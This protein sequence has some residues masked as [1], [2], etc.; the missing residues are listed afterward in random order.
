MFA[1]CV[2]MTELGAV[3]KM[4]REDRA[5]VD[6]WTERANMAMVTMK[7]DGNGNGSSNSKTNNSTVPYLSPEYDT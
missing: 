5:F 1:R 6:A 4:R 2:V 3:L 7:D